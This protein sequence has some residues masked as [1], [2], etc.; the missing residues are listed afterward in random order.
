HTNDASGAIPRLINMGVRP[1]TIGPALS[2]VIGQRLVRKLCNKCRKSYKPDKKLIAEFK[3]KLGKFYPKKGMS[4]LYK[5]S[6]KG[7]HDCHETG[8]SG[9]SGIYEIFRVDEKMEALINKRAS[10]QDILHAAIEQGMMTM[11]QDGLLKVIEGVTDM[12][13]VRRVVD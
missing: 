11:E 9:R 12:D 6:E 7:C 2:V 1:Y 5:A 4:K 10:S 13:E 8:Y 3:K